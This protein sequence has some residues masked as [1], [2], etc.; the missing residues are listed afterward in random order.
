MGQ[1]EQCNS[2]PR[3]SRAASNRFSLPAYCL[4]TL[5][6]ASTSVFSLPRLRHR[7]EARA[8][9]FQ[10][11]FFS[12]A[13]IAFVVPSFA[14]DS[15]TVT[16][17]VDGD[18]LAVSLDGHLDKVHLIGVDTPEVYESDKLH[19]DADRTGQDKATIQALG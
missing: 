2:L 11:G 19:R 4:P 9:A 16:R 8:D 1:N 15:A 5:R 7:G 3:L 14:R 17:V 12:C 10:H 13:G 6:N 18:T